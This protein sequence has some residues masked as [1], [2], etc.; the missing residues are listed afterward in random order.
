MGD[1]HASKIGAK[2]FVKELIGLP[3]KP[4]LTRSWHFDRARFH[5]CQAQALVRQYENAT[6][7]VPF[8]RD[9]LGSYPRRELATGEALAFLRELPVLPKSVVRAEQE[10][11]RSERWAPRVVNTTSGTTGT[12]LRIS[13]SLMELSRGRAAYF[14]WLAR[15][16]GHRR[17]RRIHLTGFVTPE[18][19]AD[20]IAWR[21]WVSGDI[22]LSIYAVTPSRRGE[23]GRILDRYP[24]HVISGYGSAVNELALLMRGHGVPTR[25]RRVAVVSSEILH[26]EWRE[27]IERVLC[28]RVY[29]V[30]GSQ[31]GA[32]A[33]LECEAGGRHIHPYFGIVEVV[34]DDGVPAAP[35][36]EGR[37]VVTGLLRRSMPLLR[38]DIGDR[39][40]AA[41][42]GAPCDCGLAWPRLERVIGRSEDLVLTRDGRRIGYLAFHSTKDMPGLV[43]AQLT[44]RDYETFDMHLVAEPDLPGG[45]TA[46][47]SAIRSQLTKR[48]GGNLTIRFTYSD[49]IPRT[50][51]GK[52]KAVVV[53]PDFRSR[54]EADQAASGHG[55]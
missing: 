49:R 46:V 12:P 30:Y 45:R 7:T 19:G 4:W 8:Y 50:A 48:L 54:A 29:D 2:D 3:L 18:P 42:P 38:Y 47:E 6:R 37:V 26:D 34:A 14:D 13:A 55:W 28:R 20:V 21:D 27:R 5:A 36:Q 35:G 44:Q 25:D 10:A 15:V 1:Y 9:R 32:H 40:V 31:E 39:A 43:E 22:Y 52:F 17:P 23:I 41:D 51:A 16:S 53:D 11:L 33:V 24:D